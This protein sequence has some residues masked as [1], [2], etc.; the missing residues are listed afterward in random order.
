MKLTNLFFLLTGTI[1]LF[2][3]YQDEVMTDFDYQA[4]DVITMVPSFNS[5]TDSVVY[6]WDDTVIGTEREQPFVHRFVVDNSVSSGTHTYY[7][8]IFYTIEPNAKASITNSR[9]VTI[10]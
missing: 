5:K 9:T 8:Q 3:C 2:S 4:G 10:K 7:M 1:L 6:K